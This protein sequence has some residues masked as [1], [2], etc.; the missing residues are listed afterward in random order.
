MRA[1]LLLLII[2][3]FSKPTIAQEKFFELT[4]HG[5]VSTQDTTKLFSIYYYEGKSQ[6]ELYKKALVY[7]NTLYV[8][9]KDVIS[10]VENETITI[11]GVAKSTIRQNSLSPRFDM[12]YTIV[13][14]F[15]D[16]RIRIDAPTFRLSNQ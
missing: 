9:P 2:S 3:L 1:L 7:I 15:K 10:N 5:F 13:L 6:S 11:N 12:N 4:S 14:M 8:S 16:N